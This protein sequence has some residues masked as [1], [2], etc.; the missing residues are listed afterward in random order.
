MLR[1]AYGLRPGSASFLHSRV[2]HGGTEPQVEAEDNP[3]RPEQLDDRRQVGKGTKGLQPDDDITGSA[4]YD[5]QSTLGQMSARVHHEG[6]GEPGV[7]G[8]QLAE[9]AALHRPPLNRVEIRDIALVKTQS[10]VE[11]PEHRH[12]IAD[13]SGNQ[14]GFERSVPRAVSRLGVNRDS[15]GNVQDGND[16]HA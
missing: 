5:F 13:R 4:R 11:C 1:Q 10:R 7:K 8:S 16:L 14:V 12:R 9:E 3:Q 2:Q 15:T 6:A